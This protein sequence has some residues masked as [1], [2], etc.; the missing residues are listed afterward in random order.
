MRDFHLLVRL[1]GFNTKQMNQAV[2]AFH[3]FEDASLRYTGIEGHAG[4]THFGFYDTV[5]AGE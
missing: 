4:L 3:R 1:E 2:F 5:V